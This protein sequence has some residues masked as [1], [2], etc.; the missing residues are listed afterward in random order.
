MHKAW[1]AML[2][3]PAACAGEQPAEIEFASLQPAPVPDRT[4]DRQVERAGKPP[5]GNDLLGVLGYAAL[6]GLAAAAGSKGGR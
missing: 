5:H 3:L 2:L 4:V 6:Q 1:V